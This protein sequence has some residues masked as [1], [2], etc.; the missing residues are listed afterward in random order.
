VVVFPHNT[1][2]IVTGK[3]RT[4][5]EMIDGAHPVLPKAW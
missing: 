1:S 5:P 2:R 3:G 4:E